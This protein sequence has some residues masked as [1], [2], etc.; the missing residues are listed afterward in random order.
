[1]VKQRA[2]LPGNNQMLNLTHALPSKIDAKLTQAKIQ[3]NDRFAVFS[4]IQ[5]YRY[6]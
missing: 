4:R 5:L 6:S 2:N 1:M 3:T